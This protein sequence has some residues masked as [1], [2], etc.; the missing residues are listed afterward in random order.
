MRINFFITEMKGHH[1]INKFDVPM[2]FLSNIV[3]I[4]DIHQG[5]MIE[6]KG[7]KYGVLL[8]TKPVKISDEQRKPHER[9]IQK[10]VN[11]VSTN[12]KFQT[13]AVSRLQPRKPILKYLLDVAGKSNGNKATDLH[14][15]A[16]YNKVA[17]DDTPIISWKYYTFLSLG[18]GLTVNE[19]RI[20]YEATIPG[21]LKN[22]RMARLQPR[23]YED[24]NEIA[25]A[26][27]I[28]F[29]EMII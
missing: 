22:M 3:S 18:E 1:T 13:I 12:L 6:F 24:E 17:E 4:V 23:V 11:G 2:K 16:L 28:M 7:K 25:T 8:E 9:R 27:R 14:L 10:V 15:S 20:V 19:A 29:R 5:G 26:Y 21:L